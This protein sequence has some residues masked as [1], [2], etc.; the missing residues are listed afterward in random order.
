MKRYIIA[1]LLVFLVVLLATFPAG[2]AYRW[3]APPEVQLSGITGSIWRG[4]ASEGLAAGAYLRNISWRLHPAAL[5]T[6]KLALTASASPGSGTMNSEIS[7]GLDGSL[8]LSGLSGS[9]PLDLVHQSFQQGGISGDLS[10][11]FE[12]LT[13]RNGLPV[14]AIGSVTV[15]N[16]YAPTLS[17][18]VLGTYR[19]DFQTTESGITGIVDDLSGVLDIA[20]TVT[21]APD[22]SY[23]LSGDVAAR[24]GA[25]PSIEQQLRFLG[26]QDE[27][28]M[29]PFRFEGQF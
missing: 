13:L 20:G 2:V 3:I 28:G 10:L 4:S 23:R 15:A 17:A 11:Q 26:S 22:R 21:L 18:A 27:R 19:A 5:L 25:P 6:G 29:R 14:D 12:T 1:G 8:T 16:F 9:L 7:V 24:P